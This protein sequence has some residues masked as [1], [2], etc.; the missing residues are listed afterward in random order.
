MARP[1]SAR[2]AR[3]AIAAVAGGGA[4]LGAAVATL[5]GDRGARHGTRLDGALLDE[6]AAA[7]RRG[8]AALADLLADLGEGR[9]P[10]AQVA[11]ASVAGAATALGVHDDYRDGARPDKHPNHHHPGGDPGAAGEPGVPGGGTDH[12]HPAEATTLRP[13]DPPRTVSILSF[14]AA[15]WLLFATAAILA[16]CS[17]GAAVLV[18]RAVGKLLDAC[19]SQSSTG[20]DGASAAASAAAAQPGHLREALRELL[21]LVAVQGAT[22][23]AYISVLTVAGERVASR[24]RLCILEAALKSVRAGGG[25]SC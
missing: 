10:S 3:R 19:R 20:A 15:E 17:S 25:A 22:Q 14:I 9:L 8:E 2:R 4:L 5:R 12:H 24:M 23:F 11:E 7:L 21:Q 6:L 13:A 1:R 18:P 16:L